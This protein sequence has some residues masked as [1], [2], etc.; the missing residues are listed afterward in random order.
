MNRQSTKLAESPTGGCKIIKCCCR[1]LCHNQ[2]ARHP[3]RT[4][5]LHAVSHMSAYCIA[6]AMASMVFYS[7]QAAWISSFF[8]RRAT[9]T[10]NE[11]M[12]FETLTAAFM[13]H[14]RIDTRRFHDLH[15]D[16]CMTCISIMIYSYTK[17]MR[18]SYI[19]H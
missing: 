3:A 2:R 9:L 10:R 5:T 13:P 12:K 4:L 14:I 7:Y 6:M 1:R 11:C 17:T 18:A 8:Y 15:V 19:N 16:F